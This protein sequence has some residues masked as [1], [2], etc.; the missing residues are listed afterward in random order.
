MSAEAPGIQ[1]QL[2]HLRG[3][4][5]A[6]DDDC[7]VCL[8]PI[9]PADGRFVALRF[10]GRTAHP[11]HEDCFTRFA[12]GMRHFGRVFLEQAVRASVH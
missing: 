4:D 6:T 7:S 8:V 10:V 5:L 1:V 11:F 2:V 3:L 9:T 12:H